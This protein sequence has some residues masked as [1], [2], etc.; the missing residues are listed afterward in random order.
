M[1]A[2]GASALAAHD[3]TFNEH[4]HRLGFE[5]AVGQAITARGRQR[6]AGREAA[7]I[8]GFHLVHHILRASLREGIT[9]DADGGEGGEGKNQSAHVGSPLQGARRSP[10]TSIHLGWNAREH[11]AGCIWAE[12]PSQYRLD[13]RP[14]WRP[15]VPTAN[16]PERR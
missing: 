5:F 4:H 8:F 2:I 11:V 14:L 6:L 16:K 10:A 3:A 13:S 15:G 9:G 1:V 12:M 7:R